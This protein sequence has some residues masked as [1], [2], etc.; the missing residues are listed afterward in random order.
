MISKLNPD[1]SLPLKSL[2]P[3]HPAKRDHAY[4]NLKRAGG[5][6]VERF[7]V[8]VYRF[9]EQCFQSQKRQGQI[10]LPRTK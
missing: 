1:L 4:R 8:E 6:L 3:G 9:H 7:V 2:S 5:P 10:A